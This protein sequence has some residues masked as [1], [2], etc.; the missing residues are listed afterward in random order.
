MF[1]YIFCFLIVVK[2]IKTNINIV[3]IACSSRMES[4][5]SIDMIDCKLEILEEEL[6]PSAAST[7]AET[8]LG[9]RNPWPFLVNYFSFVCIRGQNAEFNCNLCG[10]AKKSISSNLRSTYNLRKHVFRVHPS[11]AS[12]FIRCID[13]GVKNRRRNV[14]SDRNRLDVESEF[15]TVKK[16]KLAP[17]HDETIAFTNSIIVKQIPIHNEKFESLSSKNKKQI[18]LI[19]DECKEPVF[20]DNKYFTSPHGKKCTSVLEISQ[21]VVDAKVMSLFVENFIPLKVKI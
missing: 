6:T 13:E 11:A 12:E 19:Y 4:D 8:Q 1:L 14:T 16:A 3:V 20:V 21:D 17:F 18:P 2:I 15:V 7:S 10:P 5:S 9:G